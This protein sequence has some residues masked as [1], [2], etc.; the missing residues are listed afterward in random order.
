MGESLILWTTC[1]GDLAAALLI[2]LA[3]ANHPA[4]FHLKK[5][6]PRAAAIAMVIGLIG[7]AARSGYTILTGISPRDLEMVWWVGKD[8]SGQIIALW[9]FI[10][11]YKQWRKTWQK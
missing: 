2:F 10:I 6:L 4:D 7:Q 11:W 1:F 8:L 5:P 3:L 9:F